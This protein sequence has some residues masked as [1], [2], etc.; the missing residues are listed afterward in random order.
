M[1]KADSISGDVPVVAVIGGGASGA[2]TAVHVLWEAVLRALPLSIA[3]IDQQGSGARSQSRPLPQ[4]DSAQLRP[5][6]R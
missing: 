6:R 1:Y 2:L 4:P 5:R 3:L